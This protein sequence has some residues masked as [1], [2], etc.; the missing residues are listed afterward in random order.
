MVRDAEKIVVP[1]RREVALAH[2]LGRLRR[3][4]RQRTARHDDFSASL[5]LTPHYSARVGVGSELSVIMGCPITGRGVA[6]EWGMTRTCY[7]KMVLTA[8]SCSG[9]TLTLSLALGYEICN[10]NLTSLACT[11]TF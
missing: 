10:P 11:P 7:C 6:S 4:R 2:V 8:H 1:R 5:T 3:C 9:L